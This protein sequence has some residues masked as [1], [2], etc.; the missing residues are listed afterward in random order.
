ML[1]RAALLFV[2]IVPLRAQG[3]ASPN[4]VRTADTIRVE[5]GGEA[6]ATF[7]PQTFG[8]PILWP[9]LAPGGL[10]VTRAWPMQQEPGAAEDH[11]HQK[12]LWFAHGDVNGVDFWTEGDNA[13]R[14]EPTEP[15]TAEVVEHR[16]RI[17]TSNRWLAPDGKVVCTD[18]RT[19]EFF[20]SGALR[21]IDVTLVLRASHGALHF[22]DTKEGTMALRLPRGLCFDRAQDPGHA[23][24]SEGKVDAAA[25]GTRA[26]WVAYSGEVDGKAV[27]VALLDHVENLRH[28]TWWHARSYGLLAA[29]PFGRHDFEKAPPKAGDFHLAADDVL[30]L[31]YR[32]LVFAGPFERDA[33]EASWREFTRPAAEANGGKWP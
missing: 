20:A 4:L 29:N 27:G 15:I 13:G 10:P 19:H 17:V 30:T 32:V 2:T 31:R 26:R 11:P 14:I 25:W 18:R 3:P 6:F 1:A 28:P 12:S 8:R 24:T 9:L 7:V 5:L 23:Y 16:A 22:G 33:I 21:G